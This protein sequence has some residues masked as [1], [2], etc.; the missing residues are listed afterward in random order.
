MI[1]FS[2]GSLLSRDKDN[3]MIS[4]E[5]LVPQSGKNICQDDNCK[6]NVD[7]HILTNEDSFLEVPKY[8]RNLVDLHINYDDYVLIYVSIGGN[9][10]RGCQVKIEKI[11]Q[12]EDKVIIKIK[13]LLPS[14]SNFSLEVVNVPYDLVKIKRNKLIKKGLLDFQFV[15]QCDKLLY[16]E[17]LKID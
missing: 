13:R 17:T 14:A 1:N 7:F 2:I 16:S 5:S 6:C 11:I 3:K 8:H 9:N 15:D 4:F 12:E 10:V